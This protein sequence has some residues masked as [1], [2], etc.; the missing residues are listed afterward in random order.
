M[1]ADL[2]ANNTASDLAELIKRKKKDL[3]LERMS[4]FDPRINAI[5]TIGNEIFIGF[6]GM[7]ELL[8][9]GMTGDG[10]RRYLSVL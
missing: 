8:P 9:I 3:V 2:T 7:G 5:E 1:S 4:M 10:L 6:E